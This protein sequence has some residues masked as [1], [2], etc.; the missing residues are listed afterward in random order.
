MVI[1]A[2]VLLAAAR[3]GRR[4]RLAARYRTRQEADR[5]RAAYD[6]PSGRRLRGIVD[7]RQGDRQPHSRLARCRIAR[8]PGDHGVAERRAHHHIAAHIQLTAAAERGVCGAIGKRNR[9]NRRE[10]YVP[11]AAARRLAVN[12]SGRIS[13]QRHRTRTRD[14]RAIADIGR[15]GILPIGERD[16][17]PQAQRTSGTRH[18]RRCRG[19]DR[20]FV[21]HAERR[22]RRTMQCQRRTRCEIRLVIRDDRRQR[23][24]T[25]DVQIRGRTGSGFCGGGEC[26]RIALRLHDRDVEAP[27]GHHIGP[28]EIGL[29]GSHD[30]VDRHRD[31][32]TRRAAARGLTVGTDV[33][34]IRHRRRHR[35]SAS[36]GIDH[37][38]VEICAGAPCFRADG[39]GTCNRDIPAAGR[40]L[41]LSEGRAGRVLGDIVGIASARRG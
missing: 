4:Q 3:A 27:R 5:P 37:G 18:I 11:A 17:S 23:H 40:C 20:N 10:G 36:A 41:I 7:N 34:D 26:A 29:P 30:I 31:P 33:D 14:G 9:H 8:R 39:D 12:R 2:V 25:R 24:R 21:G 19:R 6:V 1:P 16:R 15:R 32:H 28:G 35:D 13:R 22:R 38:I